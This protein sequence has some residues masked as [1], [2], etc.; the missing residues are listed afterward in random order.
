MHHRFVLGML[1]YCAGLLAVVQPV[2]ADTMDGVT[3]TVTNPNLSG[4]PGDKVIWNYTLTNNSAGGLEVFFADLST[5]AGFNVGDGIPVNSFDDFGGSNIVANGH[6]FSGT[7]Y[8]F[9]SF[10]TVPESTNTG[11][12]DLTLFLLDSQNSLVNIVDFNEKYSAT[13]ASSTAI[14]EPGTLLLLASGLLAGFLVS[15]R[16]AH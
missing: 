7:L 1:F 16:A 12:F 2:T 3:F 8:L 11:F 5:P 13:I 15:R 10:P 6:T 4:S 14:P 9:Q